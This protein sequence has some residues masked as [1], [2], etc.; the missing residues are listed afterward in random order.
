MIDQYTIENITDILRQRVAEVENGRT[1]A[2]DAYTFFYQLE[3]L[4]KDCKDDV[5]P[6]AYDEVEK[7][8]KQG[9][10]YYDYRLVATQ[11]TRW[12]YNDAEID[13]YKVLIKNRQNLM[14]QSFKAMGGMTDEYG[15]VIPAAE[16][17]VSTS[18]KMEYKR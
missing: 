16:P 10:D 2:I 11:T 9:M 15:E 6:A 13:K 7:Y 14:K 18:I 12:V 1:D 5:Q 17:R 8:G 4:A 3:K